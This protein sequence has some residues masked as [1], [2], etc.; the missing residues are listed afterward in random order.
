M[1]WLQTAWRLVRDVGLTG[2]GGWVVYKQVYAAEPSTPL[3][4]F[5][6][7]C[8]WPAARSAVITVLSG[9]GSSSESPAP[10]AEPPS[11]SLPAER[12]GTGE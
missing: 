10:A 1:K 9:P 5:S 6:A 7:A 12:G 4:I 2:L 11:P 8:F 3:L